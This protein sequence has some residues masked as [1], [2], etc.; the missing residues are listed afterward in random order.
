MVLKLKDLCLDYIS[1]EFDTIGHELQLL[2][3]SSRE[4]V[5]DRL[6]NHDLLELPEHRLQKIRVKDKDHLVKIN[7]EYQNKLVQCF[8]NGNL[9]SLRFNYSHQVTDKLL[10]LVTHVNQSNKIPVKLSFKSLFITSCAY[11]SGIFSIFFKI[12]QLLNS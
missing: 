3:V 2:D 8:F 6:V 11:L 7:A 9:N 4:S 12:Y 5:L 1:E 10:H